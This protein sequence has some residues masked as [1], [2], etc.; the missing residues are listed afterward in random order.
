M[1][2]IFTLEYV[3]FY[4]D[5]VGSSDAQKD[6]AKEKEVEKEKQKW[7]ENMETLVVKTDLVNFKVMLMITWWRI[8]SK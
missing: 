7:T 4:R 1:K 5:L 8:F 2:P 6:V 3:V